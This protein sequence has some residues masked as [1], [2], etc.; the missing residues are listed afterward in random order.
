MKRVQLT[1]QIHVQSEIGAQSSQSKV[2]NSEARQSQ[3]HDTGQ[4]QTCATAEDGDV[5]RDLCITGD[6]SAPTQ[7]L[8]VATDTWRERAHTNSSYSENTSS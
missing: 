5:F 7:A 2:R 8:H 4:L 3:N 6:T 1:N